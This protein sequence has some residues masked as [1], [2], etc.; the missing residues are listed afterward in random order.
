MD[1]RIKLLAVVAY[2]KIAGSGVVRRNYM[3]R[4]GPVIAPD[5]RWQVD[6]VGPIFPLTPIATVLV[7]ADTEACEVI[8]RRQLEEVIDN[9]W[10][11]IVRRRDANSTSS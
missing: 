1:S 7:D 2:E 8:I 4:M 5:G 10:L 6:L 9:H 3:V 11:E